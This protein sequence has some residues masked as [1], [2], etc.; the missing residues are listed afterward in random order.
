MSS[1]DEYS[2]LIVY[3]NDSGLRDKIVEKG[4]IIQGRVTSN[5]KYVILDCAKEDL[6]TSIQKKLEGY[7]QRNLQV[8]DSKW[9]EDN[10][11]NKDFP[12]DDVSEDKEDIDANDTKSATKRTTS[13]VDDS[14]SI[15]QSRPKRNCNTVKK[16]DKKVKEEPKVKKC[17]D[18]QKFYIA[19]KLSQA[20]ST[21]SRLIT[22]NGGTLVE[23]P[24]DATV[25]LSTVQNYINKI[26]KLMTA[27]QDAPSIPIYTDAYIVDSVENTLHSL[28]EYNVI[29]LYENL[30]DVPKEEKIIKI[31][32]RVDDLIAVDPFVP[33]NI[34]EKCQVYVENNVIYLILCVL[35]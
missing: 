21:I 28:D 22:S 32:K 26:S 35:L 16:E 19:G 1:P 8:V 9:V 2:F 14:Q 11:L 23:D 10:F 31:T 29:K 18:D 25:I 17:F 7:I 24:A 33:D 20:F 30:Y 27:I 5:S 12:E 6:S 3:M 34:R 15:A 13:E 4:G